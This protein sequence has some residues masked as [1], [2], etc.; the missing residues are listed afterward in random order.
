MSTNNKG[1]SPIAIA[2]LVVAVVIVVAGGVFYYTHM[3]NRTTPPLAAQSQP[4]NGN[5][6]VGATSTPSSTSPA[7]STGPA[8]P[9]K[10]FPIYPASGPVGATI[11]LNGSGFAATGNIVTLN[12]LT[13]AS[14]KDL[15]SADGKTVKFVL[16][17]ALG[18]NCKPDEMCAEYLVDVT[19]GTTFDVAII[20]NGVTQDL[21]PFT[22]TGN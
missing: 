1:F 17:S 4:S 18:P 9:T 22:V 3:A 14:L 21:G 2:W 11:T 13:S 7:H 10:K 20:S 16:P 12:G 19:A 5:S 8:S 6:P 15:P